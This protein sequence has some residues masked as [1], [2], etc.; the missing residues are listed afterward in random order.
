MIRLVVDLARPHRGWL[1]IILFA[2]LVETLA[3]LAGPWPLKIVIDYAV[4]HNAAPAWL[5]S[6]LGSTRA[7]D[8][9][10]LAA[11]AALAM[12]L[13]AVVGGLASYVDNYYTES[14]GQWVA[15]DP[16]AGVRPPRA[17]LVQVLRH[18]SDRT[19]PQHDYRRRLHGTGFRVGVDAEHRCRSHDDRGDAG[20]D[21]LAQLGLHAARRV[22]H[23]ISAA[24]RCPVQASREEGDSRN[25]AA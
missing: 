12:V 10:S 18:A 23:T 11:I 6:L 14:V 15:N 1:V 13:T 20:S 25:A 22:H 3:G 19:A 16:P 21:V 24:L 4:G 2:M 9:K 17:A 8:G 7:A 5:V